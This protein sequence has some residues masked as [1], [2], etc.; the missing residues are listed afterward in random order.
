M[1]LV[2]A[3][4]GTFWYICVLDLLSHT[5]KMWCSLILKLWHHLAPLSENIK[6]H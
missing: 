3:D 4:Q 6:S 5:N 1:L 2:Q